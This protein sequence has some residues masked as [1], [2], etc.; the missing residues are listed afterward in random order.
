MMRRQLLLAV[1]LALPLLTSCGFAL[2]QAPSFAFSSLYVVAPDG[3][4]VGNALKR[5]LSASGNLRLIGEA[6]LADQAQ[7][8]LEI[9]LDQR[10]KAVVGVNTSGQVREFQLRAR[11]K[12]RLRTPQGKELIAETEILQQRDISF[13][14]SLVLAKE[15]EENFLYRDM[16]ND[17]VQ[18]LM[19]RV[20][21]VKAL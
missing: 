18:Q 5:S 16:Q 1:G 9:L 10:E 21:A 6:K 12:F 11:I 4:P 20:A 17:I 7:A 15:T 19:R 3:S 13:N 2:R 8:I 14:E